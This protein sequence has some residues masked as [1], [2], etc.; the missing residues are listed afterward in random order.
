[1]TTLHDAHN[2]LHDET[3]APHLERIAEGWAA[4][5]GAGGCMVVNG[6][7][8]G[9]WERVDALARRHPFVRP[10]FGLHPWDLGSERAADWLDRLEARLAADPRASVGEIGLDRWLLEARADD[11]RLLGQRRASMEEQVEAFLPQLAL[12][13]KYERPATIHCLR[14]L[15]DLL[16]LLRAHP[17]PARGFLLHAYGGPAEA[18]PELVELGAYFSF[19]PS[20]LEPRKKRQRL[21]YRS[22]PAERL[23]CE[24]DAPAMPPPQA[25]RTHKLPLAPDGSILNHPGNI[26]VAYAGLASLRGEDARELAGRVA[27]NFTRLF[28][29]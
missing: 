27:E 24:T 21:V 25:W 23:L 17:R 4:S 14:A 20:F 9:D 1:M 29:P 6:T 28:G 3:L 10:A 11:S 2:H 19:S 12:A 8:P 15:D 18:V 22:I 13:T 26:E 5:A 16:P 7:H